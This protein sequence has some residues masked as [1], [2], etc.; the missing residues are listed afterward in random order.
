VAAYVNDSGASKLDDTAALRARL[1]RV[2][3]G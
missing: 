1:S 3:F 2:D